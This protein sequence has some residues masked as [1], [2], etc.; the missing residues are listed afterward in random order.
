MFLANKDFREQARD[1]YIYIDEA[2]LAGLSDIAKVFDHAKELNARII[3]QGDRKQHKSV[4]RGNLFPVLEQYAGLPIGRLTENWRQTNKQYKEAVKAIAK[5]DILAGY[6]K[7][8]ALGWVKETDT[9]K[10]LVDEYLAGLKANKEM[11]V[12]APTHQKC[13]ELTA[14]I[15][16]RLKEEGKLGNEERTFE[17][18]VPLHWTEAE[19]GD[20][21][22]YAGDEV[23]QFTRSC[24]PYKAGQ[25][26]GAG[27]VLGGGELPSSK[28]MAVYRPGT[29]ALAPGDTIR[30]T[31]NGWT[32]PDAKGNKHRLDNG[33]EYTIKGFTESTKNN[34][35]GN[36]ELSNG[37]II[38]KGFGHLTH[39][40]VS[41]SH[42]SQGRTV[43]RVLIA[44]GSESV[45]AINTEQFYVS[46]S[47]ARESA[48]IFSDLPPDM[49]REAIQK[50]DIR[51]SATE[52]MGDH[53]VKKRKSKI[54]NFAKE[55]AKRYR[56]LR[57]VTLDAMGNR[58]REYERADYGR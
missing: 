10:P 37:W 48:K 49:L 14:D 51:K 16:Q 15:R 24:G 7:L 46:V 28:S 11:L 54:I 42:A 43:D 1:G 55:V 4:Q 56:R 29:L 35:S 30:I 50:H 53:P 12:V 32:L 13:D 5:G 18:L 22:R 2:P 26:V 33:S 21:F 25:R 23:I 6:D 19:K 36:I 27:D 40:Y 52:L 39:G 17:Q 57:E 58:T 41:T 38:D 34:P 47:R 3:L 45:P 31:G 20:R 9:N 8:D 44:M